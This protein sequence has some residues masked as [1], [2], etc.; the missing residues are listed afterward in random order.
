MGGLTNNRGNTTKMNRV[1]LGLTCLVIAGCAAKPED[2]AASYTSPT[3][4]SG[5]SCKQ[6]QN[7]AIRVDNA[8]NKASAA[9]NKARSNDTVGVI[10]LGLPVSS[11]SGGNVADQIASLKGQKETIEQ[12]ANLKNCSRV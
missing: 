6:L 8:L 2:I 9:Q 12:T 10:F 4:Y 5:W 3:T 1:I 11:L 7:E